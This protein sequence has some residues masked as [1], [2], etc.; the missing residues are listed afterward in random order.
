MAPACTIL[1]NLVEMFKPERPVPTRRPV[2]P[3]IKR[4]M[5][6]EVMFWPLEPVV[7]GDL[8]K[9]RRVLQLQSI[10]P[11]DVGDVE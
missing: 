11:R 10:D 5:G 6:E 4:Q 9:K 8:V 7:L 3:H 2:S 1:Q